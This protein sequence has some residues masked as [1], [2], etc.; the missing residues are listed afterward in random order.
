MNRQQGEFVWCQERRRGAPSPATLIRFARTYGGA[1]VVIVVLTDRVDSPECGGL[2]ERVR[3]PPWTRDLLDDLP[4]P[5]KQ[6][7]RS[8]LSITTTRSSSLLRARLSFGSTGASPSTRIRYR[9]LPRRERREF[10]GY[11]NHGDQERMCMATDPVCLAIIDD[12]A[13]R[14]RSTYKG[15]EYAFCCDYCRKQFEENPKR[16]SRIAH[17]ISVDL[18]QTL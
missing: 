11:E 3:V 5:D 2:T 16:Y 9:I 17:D 10:Q 18:K 4:A 13:V 15:L 6:A 14:F 1:P 12:D 8:I 7:M